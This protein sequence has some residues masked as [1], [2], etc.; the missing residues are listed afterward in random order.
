M[1]IP[2]LCRQ[3]LRNR[4]FVRQGSKRIYLGPWGD[5]QTEANYRAYINELT[6]PGGPV[7]KDA[8]DP[9]LADLALAFLKAR[10]NY[11]V[12]DGRQTGQLDRFK[13][14]L[15]FPLKLYPTIPAAD[16]GPRKLILCRN[17]ME[18]SGRFSR[19]YINTLVNCF[20]TIYR[21][22][23]ENEIVPPQALTALEAVN[24]LKRRRSIARETEPVK[25]APIADVERTLE[26]LPATLGAMVRIQL[27]TGMRPG[28]VCAMR[29]GDVVTTERGVM[30]YT[31]RTDKTDHRRTAAQKKKVFLGPKVQAI[32]TPYIDEA[33]G[34]DAFLFTPAGANFDRSITRTRKNP[35]RA[36]TRKPRKLTPCY[37]NKSYARAISRAAEAAGV[38]HWSPNQ[39]RHTYASEIRKRYGLEAAQIMLG[40]AKADVTQIY[41]ERDLQK[42]EEIAK[43]E[44]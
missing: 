16:F 3:K 41:A 10:A 4:A 19:S 5:P 7:I 17:A 21:F 28:E 40:H 44:G 42:M 23:V 2:K 18:E 22:G 39:L 26:E 11:Y 34:P 12:K 36:R 35:P 8:D 14:A 32:I 43:K 1:R 15:E 24:G 9:T 29:A 25:P 20:R 33:D 37:N 6:A 13:A 27:L 30:V 38:P 31:L